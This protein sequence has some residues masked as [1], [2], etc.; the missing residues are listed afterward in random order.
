M[1]SLFINLE[2]FSNFFCTYVLTTFRKG[3]IVAEIKDLLDTLIICTLCMYAN[4][5]LVVNFK[6]GGSLEAS[7]L[8]NNQYTQRKH[9]ILRI[10]GAPVRQKF[11]GILGNKVVQKLKLQ[12]F[13]R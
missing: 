1:V 10:W 3:I 12:F 4:I 8:S 2:C 5:S 13:L 6:D 9:C 7:F 11:G